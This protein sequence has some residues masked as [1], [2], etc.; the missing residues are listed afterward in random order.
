MIFIID[1]I[2]DSPNNF[3]FSFS[4]NGCIFICFTAINL[5][6]VDLF[7]A[8]YKDTMPNSP[9]PNSLQIHNYLSYY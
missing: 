1:N 7:L 4:D 8:L 2:F 3:F 6:L 5:T 9:L